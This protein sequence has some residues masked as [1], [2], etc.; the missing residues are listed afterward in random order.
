MVKIIFLNK[1]MDVNAQLKN[2]LFKSFKI[3]EFVKSMNL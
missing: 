2:I 3:Y 1:K